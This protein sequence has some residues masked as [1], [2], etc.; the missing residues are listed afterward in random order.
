SPVIWEL[1]QIVRTSSRT[2]EGITLSRRRDSD[3]SMIRATAMI[4]ATMRNQIGQPA[5]WINENKA[6]LSVCRDARNIRLAR[7][8][9]SGEACPDERELSVF[10]TRAGKGGCRT[11]VGA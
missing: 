8:A 4:D 5:A 7:M 2:P 9:E 1:R 10:F 3:R 11:G 6:G